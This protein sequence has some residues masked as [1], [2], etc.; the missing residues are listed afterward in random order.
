MFCSF[1]CLSAIHLNW[2]NTSKQNYTVCVCKCNLLKNSFSVLSWRVLRSRQIKFL[3]MYV[4]VLVFYIVCS[5]TYFHKKTCTCEAKTIIL[6]FLVNTN[7]FGSWIDYTNLPLTQFQTLLVHERFKIS[8][9]YS[10]LVGTSRMEHFE[11]LIYG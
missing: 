9:A 4:H 2:K 3:L 8:V 6:A 1:T 11:N 10:E 7:H 5:L